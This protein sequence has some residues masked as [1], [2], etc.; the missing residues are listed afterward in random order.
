MSD[1]ATAI[2]IRPLTLEDVPGM[3][4]I[5]AEAYPPALHEGAPVFASRLRL[6]AAYS[7]AATRGG[8]LVAYLI[9][10]GWPAQTPPPLGA[11]VTDAPSE[12][13]YIQDLAVSP[14]GR[15]LGIGRKLVQRA[16]DEAARDGLS[17]AELVAVEGAGPYWS[18]LGFREATAPPPLA[19][20]IATYGPEARWM[21]RPIAP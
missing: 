15:G 9:A 19:A 10:H 20:K 14:A 7:Q 6:A 21:T 11:V 1:H 2:S 4:R 17:R 5:E 8:E 12:V 3:L 18:A 13:L 16:F